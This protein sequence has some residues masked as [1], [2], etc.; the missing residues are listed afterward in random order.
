MFIQGALANVG[1]E[2]TTDEL[3]R[4]LSSN[5][6]ESEFFKLQPPPGTMMAAA[7]DWRCLLYDAAAI[8]TIGQVLWGAYVE[9][10]KPIHDKNQNSDAAIFIQIKN[11]HGQSDQFMIG[12]EFKDREIFIQK[13]NSSVK[14]L[15]LES[16]KSMPSQEIDEIKHSGY[17]VHIK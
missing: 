7:I 8:A 11:E 4:Y 3:L 12:K 9:F 5:I 13:F 16:P 1:R 6:P 15:N 14:R 2:I 17:W 10:V